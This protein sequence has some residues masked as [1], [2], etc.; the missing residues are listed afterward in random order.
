MRPLKA[1]WQQAITND[2]ILHLVNYL[3]FKIIEI[4]SLVTKHDSFFKM[5]SYGSSYKVGCIFLV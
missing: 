5:F 1:P 2:N 4:M 3:C